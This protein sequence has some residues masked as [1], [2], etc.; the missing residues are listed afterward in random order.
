MP[1]LEIRF[2]FG[3]DEF[4]FDR[5]TNNLQPFTEGCISCIFLIV[6]SWY[7]VRNVANSPLASYM[8]NVTNRERVALL[9]ISQ[10][11]LYGCSSGIP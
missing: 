2:I 10:S 11:G 4:D 7:L 3:I 8:F 5:G 9:I 6:K 1:I